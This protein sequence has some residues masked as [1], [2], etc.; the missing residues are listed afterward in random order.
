MTTAQIG[1]IG[2]SGL[3]QM[4]ELKDVEEVEVD[5]PFG[6]PSDS[7]ITG[8]LEGVRVAFLP[9]HGRGHRLL[10][11]ELPFRAN[12]YAMNCS[13]ARIISP[14]ASA[15]SG[16]IRDARHRHPNQ[17]L[18]ASRARPAESPFR[19]GIGAHGTFAHPLQRVGDVWAGAARP[20]SKSPRRDVPVYG[21]AR[22]LD[23][24]RVAGLPPVGHGHHRD[25][26]LQE[27]SS[28]RGETATRRSPSSPTVWH[29]GHDAVR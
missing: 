11:T 2:G 15:H 23:E 19:R 17:F 26:D 7:L 1:I 5:T 3:Y 8:T 27:A 18:T 22:V 10:P 29:E 12:I 25:D 4:P 9:R 21:G 6:K 24:G 14:R 28:R 20:R 13:A 16:T